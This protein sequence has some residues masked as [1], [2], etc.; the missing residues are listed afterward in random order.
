M[1]D[2]KFK[3]YYDKM[4]ADGRPHV[5]ALLIIARKIV[6]IMF[7]LLETKKKYDPSL[8]TFGKKTKLTLDIAL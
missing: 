8:F 3:E 7:K 1:S 5:E 2:E 6:R 4:R